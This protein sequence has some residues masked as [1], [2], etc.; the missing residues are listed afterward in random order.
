[1]P[2]PTPYAT[3]LAD[4]ARKIG[5]LSEYLSQATQ[6]DAAQILERILATDG[7][8]LDRV[9][10][11]MAT[12]SHVTKN[13]AKAGVCR[14]EVPLALA[15]AANTLHD[16]SLDLDDFEHDI[17]QLAGPAKNVQAPPRGSAA[18]GRSRRTR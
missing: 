2:G 12:G 11:L 8:V 18:S 6:Q 16:V 10:T 5:Q 4:A 1:M 7:G 3:H 17:Q 9:T 13:H 14:P 15:R